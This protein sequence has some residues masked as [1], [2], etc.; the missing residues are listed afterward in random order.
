MHLNPCRIPALLTLVIAVLA[1]AAPAVADTGPDSDPFTST[2]IGAG[3]NGGTAAGDPRRAEPGGGT[4][5]PAPRGDARSSQTPDYQPPAEEPP[6]V[7]PPPDEEQ[8]EEPAEE[9]PDEGAGEAPDT[10]AG[11]AP[12]GGGGGG[13]L[14]STGLQIGA[15]G[16]IGLGLLL[17]GLVLRRRPA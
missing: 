13:G 8:E 9:A 12:A 3:P 14:P 11:A 1:L 10:G 5:A 15:L 4:A 17:T 2:A 7:E 6:V 16:A